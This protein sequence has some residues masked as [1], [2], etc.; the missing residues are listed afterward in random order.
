MS[1]HKWKKT[2]YNHFFSSFCDLEQLNIVFA[3]EHLEF[4]LAVK[5]VGYCFFHVEHL[6]ILQVIMLIMLEILCNGT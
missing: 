3:V 2:S 5:Y 6:N 4:D 1:L